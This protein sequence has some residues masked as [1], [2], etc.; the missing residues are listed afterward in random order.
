MSRPNRTWP[1]ATPPPFSAEEDAEIVRM[2][3]CGLSSE[4]WPVALPGRT[5]GQILARRLELI[6]AGA[7]PRPKPL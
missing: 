3:E 6:D 2:T 4:H 1:T 5:V 7:C